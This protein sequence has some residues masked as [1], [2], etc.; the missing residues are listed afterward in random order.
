[1]QAIEYSDSAILNALMDLEANAF[2]EYATEL[3]HEV[4]FEDI[5]PQQAERL[6]AAA[7]KWE[8]AFNVV[9]MQRSA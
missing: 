6:C 9:K 8:S 5:T 4:G 2:V 3:C 7:S 1:M